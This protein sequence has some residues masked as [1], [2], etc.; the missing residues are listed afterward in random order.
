LAISKQYQKANILIVEDEPGIV[1]FIKTGLEYEGFLVN[2]LE[3]GTEAIKYMENNNCDLMILDIMLPDI[4]G[5]E[6][7]KKIRETGN[8]VP[9][10]MLTAKK[11]VTDRITGLNI[12]ADDYLTKPFSFDELLARRL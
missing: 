10:I 11:D 4:D 5:F 12:G 1:E 8:S 9:I 6:V 2:S 7:C 3:K